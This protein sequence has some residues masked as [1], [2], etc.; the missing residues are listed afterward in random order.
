M[1]ML[2]SPFCGDRMNLNCL[3]QRI[4]RCE[5]PPIA[6][7]VYSSKVM[8]RCYLLCACVLNNYLLSLYTSSCDNQLNGVCTRYQLKDPAPVNYS[9]WSNPYTRTINPITSTAETVENL[10]IAQLECRMK[11]N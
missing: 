1:T 9:K 11:F 6:S 2:Q 4:E 8:K 3:R 5:Y 7:D 10:M